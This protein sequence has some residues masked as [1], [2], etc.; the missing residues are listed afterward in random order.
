M[1][2]GRVA[3]QT[4]NEDQGSKIGWS[5]CAIGALAITLLNPTI[6]PEIVFPAYADTP[7][8]VLIGMFTVLMWRILNALAGTE[9]HCSAR[10]LSWSFGLVAMAAVDT[11]QPNIVLCC[12]ITLAGL[13][14]VLK[15]S[16][17]SL[18]SY[19]R[20]LPHHFILLF[21]FN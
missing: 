21:L 6:V 19:L 17:I 1:T 3:K 4:A 10:P 15:D 7:T 12:L 13:V 20:L 2:L 16:K 5:L 14:V 18:R 8:T 11:K 9:K